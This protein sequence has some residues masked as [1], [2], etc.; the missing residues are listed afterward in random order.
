MSKGAFFDDDAGSRAAREAPLTDRVN[1]EPPILKGLSV[2]EV[3]VASTVIFPLWL[4]IGAVVSRMF[5]MWQILA[6]VGIVG[7]ILSLWACAGYLAGLKRNRPDHYYWQAF[8]SRLGQLGIVASP[9]ISRTGSWDLGRS[10][11]ALP[12]A[13]GFRKRRRGRSTPH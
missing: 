9:F 1:S 13:S 6:L 2:K 5:H 7:P 12:K 4:V 8:R 3:T 11:A 10:M